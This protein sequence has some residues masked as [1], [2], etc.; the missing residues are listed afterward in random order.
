MD[1]KVVKHLKISRVSTEISAF[2]YDYCK[3]QFY[4]MKSQMH[5]SGLADIF[6]F[7][8]LTKTPPW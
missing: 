2:H 7:L 3:L 4:T 8:L 6:Y 5:N 1:K